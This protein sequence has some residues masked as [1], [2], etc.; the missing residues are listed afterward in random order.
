MK[1]LLF[2]LFLAGTNVLASNKEGEYAILGGGISSCGSVVEAY[3]K[4][5]SLKQLL[6]D[7]WTNGYITA[8]NISTIGTYDLTESID[9]N[10]RSQ[11]VLN[12]CRENPLDNLSIAVEMLVN[13]VK[14]RH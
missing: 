8:L 9:L 12:Y 11:W 6:I 4:N 2:F 1:M 10:G 7:E 13:K 14:S 3:E 5:H